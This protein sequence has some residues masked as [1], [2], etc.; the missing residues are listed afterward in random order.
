MPDE[1]W[2]I[3]KVKAELPNVK[4]KINDR[5]LIARVSGRLRSFASV[6]VAYTDN[7]NPDEYLRGPAWVDFRYSWEAIVHSLNN[8]TP[9]LV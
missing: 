9:L 2:T 3:E 4:V 1:I 6:T 5:I 7:M 8:D